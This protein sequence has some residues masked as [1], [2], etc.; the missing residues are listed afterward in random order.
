MG[1]SEEEVF[2]S[3]VTSYELSFQQ[4]RSKTSKNDCKA[5]LLTLFACFTNED[6]SEKP[7]AKFVTN[8]AEKSDSAKLPTWLDAFT[9]AS[10]K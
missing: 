3:L 2:F 6:I 4:L 8:E 10:G 9:D 5:K 1:Y 7:L